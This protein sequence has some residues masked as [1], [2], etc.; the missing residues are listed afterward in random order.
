MLSAAGGGEFSISALGTRGACWPGAMLVFVSWCGG[1]HDAWCAEPTALANLSP[2]AH[3]TQRNVLP[4]GINLYLDASG[5]MRGYLQGDAPEFPAFR[6]FIEILQRV[7]GPAKEFS[8]GSQVREIP[9]G[10]SFEIF[11]TASYADPVTRVE[12]VFQRVR[13]QDLTV[14]VTDL[15]QRNNDINSLMHELDAVIDKGMTIGVIGTRIA[16][17]GKIDLVDIGATRKGFMGFA[18]SLPVYCLLVGNR[19]AV[20]GVLDDFATHADALRRKDMVPAL[21]L[22]D[23]NMAAQP[24][25]TPQL[26]VAEN[27]AIHSALPLIS[28]DATDPD[29]TFHAMLYSGLRGPAASADLFVALRLPADRYQ[30]PPTPRDI[31]WQ[32]SWERYEPEKKSFVAVPSLSDD[33]QEIL[34]VAMAEGGAQIT[35][36]IRLRTQAFEPRLIYRVTA[37]AALRSRSSLLPREWAA[38]AISGQ[39]LEEVRRE[40]NPARF[41]HEID[42]HT[43]NLDIV[44]QGLDRSAASHRKTAP[45]GTLRVYLRKH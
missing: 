4:A 3:S 44:L 9:P 45:L 26:R 2:S 38:L 17:R 19:S 6:T 42:G 25:T 28:K 27:N 8:F 34:G 18:G 30:V 37:V 5:S 14:I 41:A 43:P 32:L 39:A 12:L 16:Y 40:R 10:H 20:Q 33:A 15:L 7:L 11:N 31:V 13:D 1:S 29:A 36:T 35:T 23:P 22:F 24:P 21:V